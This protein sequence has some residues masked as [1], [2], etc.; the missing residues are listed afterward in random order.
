M[1]GLGGMLRVHTGIIEES[2]DRIEGIAKEEDPG[3]KTD[4][5]YM[6]RNRNKME[7]DERNGIAGS[8]CREATL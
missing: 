1:D 7:D 5:L 4:K 8:Q 6:T 2:L 3:K